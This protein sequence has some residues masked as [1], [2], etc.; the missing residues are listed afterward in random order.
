[1]EDTQFS[2][3]LVQQAD[4]RFETRFE[5]TGAPPLVTDEPPPL[6]GDAGPNPS[7]LLTLAVANCLTAS[8]LFA[9]RKFRNEPGPLRTRATTTLARNTQNRWRVAGI[10]V[11]IHLGRAASDM[12]LL[13]RILAQFEDYCVVTQSVRPAIPVTVR[14]FDSDGTALTS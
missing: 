14:V 6:G 9:M 5:Q 2:I 7:R 3:E 12:K 1:M 10:A 8:L 4:Y 11:D 13:E